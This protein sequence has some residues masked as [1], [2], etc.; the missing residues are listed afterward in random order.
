[1]EYIYGFVGFFVFI[2]LVILMWA[3]MSCSGS[4]RFLI[5]AVLVGGI[6]I[7]YCEGYI[8]K[9]LFGLLK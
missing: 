1:M 9:D 8:P 7:A 4:N 3:T 2:W 5:Y 6:L